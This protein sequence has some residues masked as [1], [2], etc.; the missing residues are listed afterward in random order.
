MGMFMKKKGISKK[1]K[2]LLA[3]SLVCVFVLALCA[4]G[5]NNNDNSGNMAG[6]DSQQ[7]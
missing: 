5:G 4:C 3:L 7:N 2:K 1:M 6:T